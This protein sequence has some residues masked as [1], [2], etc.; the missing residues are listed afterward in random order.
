MHTPHPSRHANSDQPTPGQHRRHPLRLTG[1]C[2]LLVL[3][4]GA[5]RRVLLAGG[6]RF[7]IRSRMAQT[8][9]PGSWG[10]IPRR[11]VGTWAPVWS[12]RGAAHL[13]AARRSRL[14]LVM[15]VL[16]HG[17]LAEA[18]NQD[19][20]SWLPRHHHLHWDPWHPYPPTPVGYPAGGGPTTELITAHGAIGDN[21]TMNTQPINNAVAACVAAGGGFVVVPAGV[22]LTGTVVLA[23]NC[24]LM[25]RPGGVLQATVNMS[26]YGDDPD[27]RY[28]VVGKAIANSGVIAPSPYGHSP[29]AAG[30]ALSGTMWQSITGYDPV[31]NAFEKNATTASIVRREKKKKKKG[32]EERKVKWGH[33]GWV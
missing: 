17:F 23:S 15:L 30:G 33:H 13:T 14:T 32:G 6:L 16:M 4:T 31:Q 20:H 5:A 10:R 3:L 8:P 9:E 29:G 22:F 21:A 25:L 11:F 12:R 2:Y 27:F 1:R 28:L 18:S 19:Q 24:Y 26:Q 7:E